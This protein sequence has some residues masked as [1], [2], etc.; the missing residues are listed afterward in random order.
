MNI[1]RSLGTSAAANSVG[2][3]F[4]LA[5]LQELREGERQIDDQFAAQGADTLVWTEHDDL[6]RCLLLRYRGAIRPSRSST[7]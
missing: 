3:S 4:V 6:H 7:G 5:F 1:A 2:V